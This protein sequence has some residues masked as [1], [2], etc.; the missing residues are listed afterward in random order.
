MF[1]FQLTTSFRELARIGSI[2]HVISEN[3]WEIRQVIRF[4][5]DNPFWAGNLGLSQRCRPKI[6]EQN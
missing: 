4:T 5:P 1:L 6:H 2:S 3:P